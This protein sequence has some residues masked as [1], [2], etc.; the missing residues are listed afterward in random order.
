MTTKLRTDYLNFP[1]FGIIRLKGAIN[2][3]S[4][5]MKPAD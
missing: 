5:D 4:L 3:H 2:R 1:T